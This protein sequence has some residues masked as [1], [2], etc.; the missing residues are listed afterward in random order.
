MVRITYGFTYVLMFLLVAGVVCGFNST[1]NFEQFFNSTNLTDQT[2][3][4]DSD[5]LQV[6]GWV[7]GFYGYGYD[8]EA[9]R[10]DFVDFTSVAVLDNNVS[11]CV[12]FWFKEESKISSRFYFSYNDGAGNQDAGGV[13]WQASGV[14]YF[15]ITTDDSVQAQSS[16]DDGVCVTGSWCHFVWTYD[17]THLYGYV[18]GVFRTNVSATGPIRNDGS[19][20]TLANG[21]SAVHN[22]PVDGVMD[23]AFIYP[24]FNCSSAKVLELYSSTYPPYFSGN[25]SNAS[26]FTFVNTTV[27]LNVTVVDFNNVSSYRISH[28]DS[29]GGGWVNE[30]RV[31]ASAL[32]SVDVVWNRTLGNVSVGERVYW[33]VWANDSGGAASV[34]D[35]FSFVAGRVGLDNCSV[36]N[37]LK[38]NFSFLDEVSEDLITMDAS[39]VFNYS[40]DLSNYYSYSFSFVDRNNFSICTSPDSVTSNYVITYSNSTY[41]QRSYNVVGDVLSGKV[42]VNLYSLSSG[43]GI[44]GRF[45][46][47]DQFQS[48][49][50]GASVS[51]SKGGVTLEQGSTDGSGLVTIWL[52]PDVTYDFVFSKSGY[53]SFSTSLRVTTTEIYTVELSS[54]STSINESAYVGV[55][56]HFLPDVAV[57]VN[58][59]GYGFNFSLNVSGVSLSDCDFYLYNQSNLLSSVVGSFDSDSCFASISFNTA[60]YSSILAKAVYVVANKE[61]VL[62][63]EYGVLWSYEGQFSLKNFLD[64][65]SGLGVAGFDSFTRMFLALIVIFV[66]VAGASF[67]LGYL[68]E[69]VLIPVV[70]GGVWF[71][72]YVGWFYVDLVSIPTVF[73]KKYIIAVVVSFV[74]GAFL[75]ERVRR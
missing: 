55:L 58:G 25:S 17:G 72:S 47:V 46:V 34:S 16:Y 11:A 54:P 33:R 52:D 6:T 9:G 8:F 66:V 13:W 44:Y 53:T 43:E 19:Y 70:V 23:D 45:K 31:L 10:Q 14:Y 35:V 51:M 21:A 49:I 24:D 41:P 39:G 65:V 71:F 61:Y 38:L 5:Q 75:L 50:Q 42:N 64:D 69:E 4:L 57:L 2:G 74:A 27:Q 36:Y 68:D 48:P 32:T 59:T 1:Y 67:W 20:F 22:I 37:G 56:Y 63:R 12:G 40:G 29:V 26:N 7:D 62:S 18:N 3:S 60:N 15:R 30:T 28:T 73:A